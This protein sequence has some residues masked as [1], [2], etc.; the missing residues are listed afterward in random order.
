[1]AAPPQDH[2]RAA[3]SRSQGGDDGLSLHVSDLANMGSLLW[4][5]NKLFQIEQ[6]NFRNTR[7]LPE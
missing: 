4:F 5:V 3:Q 7:L 6:I 1:M 2:T